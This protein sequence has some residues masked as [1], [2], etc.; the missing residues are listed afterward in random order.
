MTMRTGVWGLLLALMMPAT[1]IC[2][3]VDTLDA[4]ATVQLS[5]GGD[6]HHNEFKA[7]F[8]AGA[9]GVEDRGG[10][11][12][13]RGYADGRSKISLL[14][15]EAGTESAPLMKI[16]GLDWAA[17]EQISNTLAGD[18]APAQEESFFSRHWVALSLGAAAVIVVA[19]VASSGGGT[20]DFPTQSSGHETTIIS[21]PDLPAQCTIPFPTGGC[22][23]S[24]LE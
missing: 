14:K 18:A 22:I 24:T 23:I 2:G 21:G 16:A 10:F 9:T 4:R 13:A 1:G 20:G 3:G 19:A 8:A 5:F 7:G 11:S 17:L 12:M 15:F 6:R